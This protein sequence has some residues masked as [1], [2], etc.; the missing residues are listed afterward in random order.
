L[1]VAPSSISTADSGTVFSRAAAT[2]RSPMRPAATSATL[3][4]VIIMI[5]SPSSRTR[6]AG[7]SM[8]GESGARSAAIGICA[9]SEPYGSDTRESTS[10]GLSLDGTYTYGEWLLMALS[11]RIVGNGAVGNAASSPFGN[12]VTVPLG[13]LTSSNTFAATGAAGAAG[14]AGGGPGIPPACPPPARGR[15]CSTTLWADPVSV[16]N[17]LLM[18]SD[19][20]VER[21][22]G[23]GT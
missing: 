17:S 20:A 11:I 3:A 5:V 22:R 10:A 19:S 15:G 8:T 14:A 7:L 13:T 21:R 18:A 23:H 2:T 12:V 9:L 4:S 6:P 16:R 1:H